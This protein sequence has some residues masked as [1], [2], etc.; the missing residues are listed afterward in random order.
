MDKFFSLIIPSDIRNFPGHQTLYKYLY[1][2]VF[3]FI[4]MPITAFYSIYHLNHSRYIESG[5]IFVMFLSLCCFLYDLIKKSEVRKS[6][7]FQEVII[8]VFLIFFILSQL[9]D[10]WIDQS[11]GSTPWFL[12]FPVLIFF[13]MNIK[14]ALIWLSCI[15]GIFSY[16]LFFKD[17]H[18]N[19][20]EIFHLKTRLV[21][22]FGILAII[23]LI[24]SVVIRK[25]IQ[26]LFD[27]AKVTQAINL[28]LEKQ[29]NEHK[30]AEETLLKNE[31]IFRLLTENANDVIWTMDMDLNYTY[32]SPT[33]EKIQGWSAEEAASLTVNN[34]LTPAS[35]E[36][37]FKRIDANLAHGAK[38][39]KYDVP[40]RLE[41]E[42]YCK[43]G[44]TIL[45]EI[46][47]SFILGEDG[48]PSGILGVTRDMT[49]R[50][51]LETQLQRAQQMEAIGTLAGG[52][53]HD[54]NN[55]L[56]AQVSYPDLLLMDL[57]EDSPLRIPILTIQK[58][59]RK[60][61]TIVQ[62]L[63]T[64]AR[65]GVVATEIVNLNNIIEDY[66]K[67]PECENLLEFH[68][69]VK[70]NC[71]LEPSLLN[72]MGSS[73]HLATTLTNMST[74]AA[75]AM[76]GGGNICISTRNKYLDKPVRGYE[77]IKEGDYVILTISD[78]GA[79]I[80]SA[81]LEKIFEPFYTKKV[82]GR[83]GTGLGMAVVWGT[84]KD[85]KGYIEV[86]STERKGATFTLFFPV[87]RKE[88]NEQEKTLPSA[89]YMGNG[90]TILVVDDVEEQREIAFR[91]L[92]ILNYFVTTVSS[93]EEAIEYLK[94][95]SADLLVLDMIM[96]PGID[97]LETYQKILE[98][99]PGQ[100]AII[101]SGFSE[102]EMVKEAQRLGAGE[103]L[104]K[105]YTLA[106]IGLAVKEEFQK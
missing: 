94:I 66:I 46:S 20:D 9:Y 4:G 26:K 71:D 98:F 99:H 83:S 50:N 65:R 44:T 60:A 82:M 101:A 31:E 77:E 23:A 5:L 24:L 72:I 10:L 63:L 56:S 39:G 42:L 32:I 55:I 84:V 70:I 80:S 54:L 104:K 105:P 14:E 33:I 1:A 37:A 69:G 67:S 100:K 97:G 102:T 52:V 7:L 92:K 87:T 16:F 6:D 15:V 88:I 79:G 11:L 17:L 49:E 27:N 73:V 96:D 38:T 41:L 81:D 45:T 59:G 3:I 34:V 51:K 19:P 61:A 91:L 22:I 40:E 29:I 30:Q 90:E 62:D 106:K 68:K 86:Q 8:R 47:A 89:E 103:Y 57:P 36:I 21:L 93:G 28:R 12:I 2:K 43:G 13:S 53:A 64:L 18:F 74:N 95:N 58:S 25:T 78:N 76:P 48:K 85:H 35:M 75:E